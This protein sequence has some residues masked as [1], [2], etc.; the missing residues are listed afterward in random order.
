MPWTISG[1]FLEG[2]AKLALE[3]K[4]R[5]TTALIP[6]PASYAWFRAAAHFLAAECKAGA[7]CR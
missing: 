2:V 6:K 5:F 4:W 1:L 3:A 7:A